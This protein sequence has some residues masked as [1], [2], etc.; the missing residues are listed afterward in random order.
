MQEDDIIFNSFKQLSGDI[1]RYTRKPLHGGLSNN[2]QSVC[3]VNERRY[4]VRALKESFARRHNEIHTHLLA[5]SK[6]IAP[7]IHYY[8][9]DFSFVILDFIDD[10][11]L[12]IQ[13][14]KRYDIVNI[15]AQKVRLITQFDVSILV[16]NDAPDLFAQIVADYNQIKDQ[17]NADFNAL[18]DKA[19]HD[20]ESIYHALEKENRPLVFNHNDLHLRNI[21]FT[22][23]DILIIDWETAALNY[24]LYDL[25]CYSV[26]ACL[27]EAED[28]YLLTHYLQRPPV[29][30]DLQH[31]HRVKLMLR[32][33]MAFAFL[34][35]L[36]PMPESVPME[37]V[38]D[39]EYYMTIFAQDANANSSEF[40]YALAISFLQ[41]FFKE[42]DKF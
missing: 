8:D 33:F 32:V 36:E 39:F 30:S 10:P 1:Y 16:N 2:T 40:L 4:V 11:T 20:V 5:A 22:H 29:Y 12:L 9:D 41:E 28:Q 25:A 26:Y 3:T 19:L 35:L 42:Y 23:D 13:Q 21:F 34:K 24:E 7:K 15:I 17:G 6:G 18:I 27:N 38:K 37:A 14:A 31:Y